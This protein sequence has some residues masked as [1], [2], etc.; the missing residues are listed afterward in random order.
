MGFSFLVSP[1]I[2]LWL[3][4]LFSFHG[5][6]F[7]SFQQITVDL[8]VRW[9]IECTDSLSDFETMLCVCFVYWS[10][11]CSFLC[12]LLCDYF[13]NIIVAHTSYFFF[14][15]FIHLGGF[16][17]ICTLV[18]SLLVVIRLAHSCHHLT[19]KVVQIGTQT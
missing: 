1:P 19:V 18:L 12:F 7:F 6:L 15:S 14:T 16:F 13:C 10:P 8:F 2:L 9:F 17:K 5:F 11:I 3:A 4:L